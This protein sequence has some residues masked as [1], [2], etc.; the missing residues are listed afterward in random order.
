MGYT[1]TRRTGKGEERRAKIQQQWKEP[2]D[3]Q[4]RRAW[5]VKERE[6]TN[7]AREKESTGESESSEW[8]IQKTEYCCHGVRHHFPGAQGINQEVHKSMLC[9]GII[10]G[11]TL[12]PHVFSL[13][14]FS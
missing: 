2:G 13:L 6:K 8:E 11:A 14:S 1:N 4:Q 10:H 5:E 9:W 3:N 7:G 12:A